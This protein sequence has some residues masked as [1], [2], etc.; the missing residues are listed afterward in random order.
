MDNR[1]AAGLA[2]AACCAC[3]A[4]TPTPPPVGPAPDFSVICQPSG[5]GAGGGCGTSTCTVTSLNGFV[6]AV[7]LSCSGAPAGLDCGFG[8]NP[9]T[10]AANASARTGFTVAALPTVPDRVYAFEVAAVNGAVR[11]TAAVSVETVSVQP[12]S[13]VSSRSF[14]VSGC[15]CYVDGVLGNGTLQLFTSNFVVARKRGL[16]GPGCVQGLAAPNG[17][18][19]L[20]IPRGC[21]A[22]GE[23]F[24]LLA[25]GVPTCTTRAFTGGSNDWAVLLGRRTACP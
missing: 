9:L 2:L 20:E 5:F 6:G 12:P 1:F 4:D 14:M 17:R 13:P 15:T 22:E 10:L 25:G 21:F 3:G 16:G 19:D 8:P 11:R 24:D 23:T 7:T 18:F